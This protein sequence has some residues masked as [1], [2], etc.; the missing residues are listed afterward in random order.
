MHAHKR[1]DSRTQKFSTTRAVIILLFNYPAAKIKKNSQNRFDCL[2]FVWQAC[3]F[4]DV[5]CV[6]TR[7]CHDALLRVKNETSAEI[8]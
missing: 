4:K 8:T 2:I 6:N 7:G 1:R 5:S 3:K